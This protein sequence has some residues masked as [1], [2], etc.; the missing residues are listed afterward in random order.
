M[1]KYSPK[2]LFK[3]ALIEINGIVHA[4]LSIKEVSLVWRCCNYF[5]WRR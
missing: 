1:I 2:H 4:D 3:M 5:K